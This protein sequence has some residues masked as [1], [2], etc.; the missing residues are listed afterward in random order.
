MARDLALGQISCL[1]S[2]RPRVQSL[3]LSKKHRW[4]IMWHY[5]FKKLGMHLLFKDK[6]ILSL[7]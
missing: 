7:K 4:D 3:E 2:P 5:T 1:A 6:I